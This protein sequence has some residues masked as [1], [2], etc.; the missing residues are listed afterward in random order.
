MPPIIL[1]MVLARDIAE[2]IGRPDVDATRGEYYLGAT[3]PDIRVITRGSRKDTH[4]FDLDNVDHQDSVAEL[5]KRHPA[6][7]RPDHLT[8]EAASFMAG[9]ITHLTMDETYITDLYR[10]FFGHS[11]TMGG[12]IK[13]NLMDR[14]LQFDLDRQ[15]RERPQLMAHLREALC[16]THAGLQVGFLDAETLERW[17]Q[18]NVEMTETSMDWDRIRAMIG[19][20]LK[21][22]GVT[23]E[24]EFNR[25]LDSLPDLLDE[26]IAHITSDRVRGFVESAKDRARVAMTRYLECG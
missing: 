26:T 20:H 25:L 11:S 19:R 23:D 15:E 7:A 13:A 16:S 10:P 8:P 3:T 14:L 1:H 4:F 21:Y 9:Y 6:L 12:D 24:A 17:R 5:F 18:I 22:S 2:E